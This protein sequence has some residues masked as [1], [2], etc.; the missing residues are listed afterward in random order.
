MAD[1]NVY[2]VF[3]GGGADYEPKVHGIFQNLGLAKECVKSAMLDFIEE[4]DF[5]RDAAGKSTVIVDKQKFENYTYF[6]VYQ[7]SEERDFGGYTNIFA[8][9][10]TTTNL[11]R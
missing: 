2:V 5:G 9:M 8:I 6:Y 11:I 1:N 10:S 4:F 7:D 3:E